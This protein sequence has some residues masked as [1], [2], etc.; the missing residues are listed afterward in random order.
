MKHTI[1]IVIPI[2]DEFEMT[3][4]CMKSFEDHA[5][6]KLFRLNFLIID[7]G[8]SKPF[9]TKKKNVTVIRHAQNTG[10]LASLQE[11]Y[12]YVKKNKLGDIIFYTHNDVFIHEDGWDKRVL[13]VFEMRDNIGVVGFGGAKG[14]GSREI[15]RFPYQKAHMARQGFMSNMID[16]EKHG[17]RNEGVT[18]VAVHD[19]FSL[20]MKVSL[21]DEIGGFD[22]GY[23]MHHMYDNDIC[24]EAISHG[25]VNMMVGVRCEHRGG[26]T[27]TR[28]K[29]MESAKKH[30]KKKY[31]EE[32]DNGDAAV[33]DKAHEYF[34][35]K[36]KERK[37]RLPYI[38]NR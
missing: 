33:H 18:S 23:P 15:Y 27:S 24:L 5:S 36:W 21:L 19:G 37:P 35:H 10:L 28:P 20:I 30:I 8:S 16:A 17:T 38:E 6:E 13:D 34:Y 14:M 4:E 25:Y 31:G 11:G 1:C 29:Y 12:E 3:K 32:V 9:K 2:I 7:N 26:I 22:M